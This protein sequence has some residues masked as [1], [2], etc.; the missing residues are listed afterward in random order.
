MA[1]KDRRRTYGITA[2]KLSIKSISDIQWNWSA[3]MTI[4]TDGPYN[5]IDE[6][7][8]LSIS[9]L[10]DYTGNSENWYWINRPGSMG[11]NFS[12]LIGT[13]TGNL[14]L[15]KVTVNPKATFIFSDGSTWTGNVSQVHNYNSKLDDPISIS[16]SGFSLTISGITNSG[17]NIQDITRIDS[18][19]YGTSSSSSII[20]T[21]PLN[22][23]DTNGTGN[24]SI[25]IT[26]YQVIS[27]I[28]NESESIDESN[29]LSS[30]LQLYVRF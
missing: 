23:R 12:D 3:N 20:L 30:R 5:I 9:V 11:L 18:S 6:F 21:N 2:T 10:P 16:I 25:G 1:S 17:T 4:L 19:S 8:Q 22:S 24:M 14:F 27:R 7:N 28:V 29:S 26:S 15:V 13:Y